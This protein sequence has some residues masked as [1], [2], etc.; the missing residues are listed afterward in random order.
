MIVCAYSDERRQLLFAALDSLKCQVRR[1]NEI[2][3]VIDHNPVL[4]MLVAESHP[5]VAIYANLE[6][7]GLSGARNTGV[8]FAT[9]EVVAFLDDDAV[10]DAQWLDRL[11][12]HYKNPA[13]MG[14][15]G[16]VIA[17]WPDSRPRWFPAE[18]DWVVGCSYKGQPDQVA[19]VRNPIGCNM[20]FRRALFAAIGGF[21]EGIGRRG[22]DATGCEE[23]EFCIRAHL[24]FPQS[25][26]QFDPEAKVYHHVAPDRNHWAY[27]R[28]RCLAEGRSKAMVVDKV[29]THHGLS[30]ERL[31]ITS[32]LPTGVALG[33][34]H[35]FLKRD[36]WGMVRAG[37]IIAGLGYT[38][39]GYVSAKLQNYWKPQMLEGAF[40][41]LRILDLEIT[42]PLPA[43]EAK[44]P[45]TDQEWGG[46]FCLVRSSGRPIKVLEIPLN[47][48]DLTPTDL[49]AL[50]GEDI[51]APSVASDRKPVRVGD[52]P[53]TSIIVATRDRPTSL[54]SCLDLL[55]HQDYGAFD[56]Y[57]VDNA[58]SSSETADLV[59]SRYAPT[60][61]VHYV[62]E[63]RPGLGR[64]HNSGLENVTASVTAFTDDDVIADPSWLSALASNFDADGRVGC[65]TGLILP[66]ELETRAQ[67]WT[68]KHGGFGKGFKRKIYD[69]KNHRPSGPLFP[70]TAGQFGSGANMAFRTETLRRIGGF[71]PALG[72]G[73][74]A[75]GGDDL[76]AFFAVVNA[77]YQLVYEPE[78]II[79]HHHRRSEE[80]MRKQAFSYGMGLGA[81]LTKLIVDE[82][83][84]ALRLARILPA[85]LAHMMGASSPKN[86]HLPKD[87]PLSLV[88]RERLG[89]L[90]GVAG[91]IRSRAASKH[92]LEITHSTRLT[93]AVSNRQE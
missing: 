1:P 64:A 60:G 27:F 54:A 6:T 14:V 71:D 20:S 43:I 45:I 53:F 52:A 69:I 91:Y 59:A 8:K 85:G 12:S 15:G 62:R 33:L 74:M 87:Y 16:G 36:L 30:S 7:Q 19:P 84:T 11:L 3:A 61:I 89:V 88:W 46:V 56:I 66:A 4:Q 47:G 22:A 79:W 42:Q 35:A 93:P 17:M 9:G 51:H 28:R 75:R 70:Y 68:E 92:H 37:S 18:F 86:Q 55:L 72:A 25:T 58:P 41:P 81:Y 67:F 77:A 26:I 63:N 38:I 40:Q 49:A 82:P 31:Y 23:T 39:Y 78:A 5:D 48:E 34:H 29:G 24:A 65:V 13:V 80:G 21:S 83:A 90:A 57:V 76:A 73:T 32:V 44:N 2:I 10:A 50:L